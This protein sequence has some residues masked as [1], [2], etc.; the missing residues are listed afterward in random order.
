M[1]GQ[2]SMVE[3]GVG[4][5]SNGRR[6]L[7]WMAATVLACLLLA[8]L[9][10]GADRAAPAVHVVTIQNMQFMPAALTVRPGEKVMWINK[11][12]VPHTASATDSQFDSGNIAAG[13]SWTYTVKKAGTV[14]YVC[15][16]HPG[17]QATLTAQ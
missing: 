5:A 17:M 4:R 11:D 10:R 6:S 3:A 1:N 2:H 14:H 15:R 9:A 16:Y 8:P 13:A 7:M 12:L